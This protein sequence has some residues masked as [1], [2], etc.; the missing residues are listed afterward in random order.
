[1]EQLSI[2]KL[3]ASCFAT[4]ERVR[5]TRTT[6]LITRF[7]EPIAEIR[8]AAGRVE[9][10]RQLGQMAGTFKIIGNIVGPVFEEDD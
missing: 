7:G 5:K 9:T 6:M 4:I 10:R 3:R 1:M 2:S 8:P